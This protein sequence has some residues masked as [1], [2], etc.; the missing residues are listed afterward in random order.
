M[1]PGALGAESDTSS[2]S[3]SSLRSW[4]PPIPHVER[5]AHDRPRLAL[6]SLDLLQHAR[7]LSRPAL[8][9]SPRPVVPLP[10]RPA[11]P[12]ARQTP[13]TPPTSPSPA[14]FLP[15]TWLD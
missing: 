4:D 8:T 15:L 1:S 5:G 11:K 10:R 6:S 3:S 2:S 14:A 9:G 7:P 12:R 13:P